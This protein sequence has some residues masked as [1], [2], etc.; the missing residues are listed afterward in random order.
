[1]RNIASCLQERMQQMVKL[2]GGARAA[3][4]NHET[5]SVHKV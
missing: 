2:P 3:P 1:M 4:F 5:I